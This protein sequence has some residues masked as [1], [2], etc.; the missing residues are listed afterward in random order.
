MG[1]KKIK[2]NDAIDKAASKVFKSNG[3]SDP[4]KENASK[5]EIGKAFDRLMADEI[6]MPQLKEAYKKGFQSE[7]RRCRNDILKLL[8][9]AAQHGECMVLVTYTDVQFSRNVVKKT[10]E[11][12]KDDGYTISEGAT[13]YH[14]WF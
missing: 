14:V 11:G 7:V 1:D 9:K 13:T 3:Q 12:L 2:V 10:I 6:T 4:F 8:L 5:S